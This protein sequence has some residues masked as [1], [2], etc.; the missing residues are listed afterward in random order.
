MDM[1]SREKRINELLKTPPALKKLAAAM[2]KFIRAEGRNEYRWEATK[3]RGSG[4][5]PSPNAGM[6]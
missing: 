6:G 1:I 4:P 3:V 5:P 2:A